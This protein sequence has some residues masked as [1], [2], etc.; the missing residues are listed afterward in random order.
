MLVL[1]LIGNYLVVLNAETTVL[2]QRR[3]AADLKARELD[4]QIALIRAL[5]GGY[6]DD[7]PARSAHADPE[8][9]RPTAR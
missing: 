8:P 1:L 2:G 7:P 3:I 9:L 4:T 6:R 5:G